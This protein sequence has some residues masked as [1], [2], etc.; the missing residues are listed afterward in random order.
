LNVPRKVNVSLHFSD[1]PFDLI[2]T[3]ISI[4]VHIVVVLVLLYFH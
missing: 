1:A 4:T 2:I 3:F